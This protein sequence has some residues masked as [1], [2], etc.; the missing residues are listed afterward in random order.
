MAIASPVVSPLGGTQTLTFSQMIDLSVGIIPGA[1]HEPHPPTINTLTHQGTGLEWMMKT[2]GMQQSDFVWSGG[3]GCCFEEVTATTHSGTH[4]DAPWHYG[5]TSEGRPARTVDELPLEWFFS[6]GVVLDIRHKQPNERIEIADLE[7]ALAKIDYRLKPF[8]IVMLWSGCDRNLGSAEYFEQPGM[9]R[10]S[11]LWLVD[12]GIKVIGV[13]MYGFDR[14]FQDMADEFARTGDG[15]CV[16][17]AHFAGITREYCQIEKL[18]NLDKLPRPTDFKVACF[19][20]K[21]EG[22][23]GGWARPVAFV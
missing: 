22:A 15:R 20:I 13:D 12:Q 17:E 16:W 19:P 4:V 6:D 9:T 1:L 2:F 23:S 14:K 11:T 21:V 3:E 7:A 5:R 18:V 10:D 8:D